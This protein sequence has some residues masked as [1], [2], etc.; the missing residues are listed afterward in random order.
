[1]TRTSLLLHLLIILTTLPASAQLVDAKFTESIFSDK[2]ETDNGNWK[3]MSNADNLFLIQDGTYLLQR[4]NPKSVYSIFPKWTNTATTFEIM[5]KLIVG[6]TENIESG[7]GIIFMAQADGSGA[8]VLEINDNKQYRLKQLVGVNFRLL[9]GS[10][11]TNG[12]LD[13]PFLNG[14]DEVN[15]IQ[16]KS[17]NRNYDIHF[18]QNY[19]FSFTEIAYKTGNIGISVGPLSKFKIEEFAVY[20]SSESGQSVSDSIAI[21]HKPRTD[22]VYTLQEEINALKAENKM[23]RDSIKLLLPPFKKSIP[24][25]DD[26]EKNIQEPQKH[27]E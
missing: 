7:A 20:T 26:P 21:N 15:L 12:W 13:S 16:V 19:I 18:N 25:A 6:Q 8:F 14:K 4:K 17:S 27:P 1:M 5:V 23:L 9:T 3:I 2:F 11:K 22:S 10:A 24:Q